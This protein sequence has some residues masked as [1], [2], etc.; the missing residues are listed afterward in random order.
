MVVQHQDRYG[1]AKNKLH[2]LAISD[3]S[4]PLWPHTHCTPKGVDKFKNFGEVEY[5]GPEK[6]RPRWRGVGREANDVVE[7]RAGGGGDDGEGAPKGH[8]EGEK[9]E[10]EAVEGCHWF[11]DVGSSEGR[12]ERNSGEKECEEEVAGN[13]EGEELVGGAKRLAWGPGKVQDFWVVH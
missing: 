7:V 4:F 13:C 3:Q 10:H 5:V 9:E 8:D 2:N 6:E 12:R 1:K 11:E